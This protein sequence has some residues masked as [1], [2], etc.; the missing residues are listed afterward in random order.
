[1]STGE[2]CMSA[3][4][5]RCQLLMVERGDTAGGFLRLRETSAVCMRLEEEEEE[6][7]EEEAED[8]SLLM[9]MRELSSSV[10][11]IGGAAACDMTEL[12][13]PF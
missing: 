3:G 11:N 9:L 10:I 7:E 1:M 5:G 2:R 6:A 12:F 8:G 4:F 13:G